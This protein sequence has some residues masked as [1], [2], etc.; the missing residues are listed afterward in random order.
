MRTLK[1]YIHYKE[2]GERFSV[3]V[4]SDQTVGELVNYINDYYQLGASYVGTEESITVLNYLGGDL[5]NDWILSDI[6]I[7]SGETL[8]CYLKVEKVPDYLIYV[9]FRNE[10]IKYFDDS[11]DVIKFTVFD[12]RVKLSKMLGYP[13]SLFHLKP[14]DENNKVEMLDDH[15]IIDYGVD[16]YGQLILGNLNFNYI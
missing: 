7:H 5:K 8:K 12:L 11:I 4:R 15:R 9:K 16:R 1:L 10:Y 6:N 2:T 14:N 3:Q 13:L